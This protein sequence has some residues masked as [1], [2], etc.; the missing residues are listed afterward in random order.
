MRN[1]VGILVVGRAGNLTNIERALVEAGAEYIYIKDIEDFEK[2][3][4]ILIPGVGSYKDAMNSIK[5][6]IEIIRENIKKKPTL[7]ICLG[8]QI[9]GQIGFENG[10]SKGIG[11]IEGEVRK[12]EVKAKTPHIG[13]NKL[14]NRKESPLFKDIPEDAAFYFMHSFELNNYIDFISLTDYENHKFVSSIQRGNI[15]GVQFHPEKS[16]E[17]GIQLLRNF[18]EM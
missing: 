11:V 14:T 18:L 4:K 13:W 12:M 17:Y 16:R 8:M 15:F 1:K 7:G 10:E 5:D 9:L 2:I 3:N 6:R